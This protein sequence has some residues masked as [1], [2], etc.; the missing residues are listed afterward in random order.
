MNENDSVATE[1]LRFGD[2]DR[3]SAMVAC[4]VNANLLIL[5]TDVNGVY[6]ANPNVDPTAKRIA[7]IHDVSKHRKEIQTGGT[8]EFSTGGMDSKLEAAQIATKSGVRTIVM[9]ASDVR[10]VTQDNGLVTPTAAKPFS[11]EFGTVFLPAANPI[12]GTRR[13]IHSL[14]TRGKIFVDSGAGRALQELSNL[15]AVGVRKV[16]GTF[17]ALD[18]VAIVTLDEPERVLGTALTNICAADLRLV[19][20]KKKED[21]AAVVGVEQAVLPVVDRHYLVL[22]GKW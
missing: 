19:M 14:P 16:E 4:L 1:E 6:T 2:N 8:S 9:L 10:R 11:Y 22:N 20:G 7:E 18:P 3:L 13:W 15:F 5:L 17:Q 21:A 12:T